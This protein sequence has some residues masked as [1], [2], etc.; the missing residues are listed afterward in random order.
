VNFKELLK[1]KEFVF[2]DGAMGT[3]LQQKGLQAGAI[4]E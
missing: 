4:P 1:N 2:F 3:M